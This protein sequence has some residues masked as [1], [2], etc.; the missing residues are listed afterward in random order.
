MRLCKVRSCQGIFYKAP[1]IL[2]NVTLSYIITSYLFL[3]HLISSIVRHNHLRSIQ[4]VTN[5]ELELFDLMWCGVVWHDVI[6][7][8]D[9]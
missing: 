3:S 4:F 6:L 9:S 2:S 1:W 8:S 7:G 5:N